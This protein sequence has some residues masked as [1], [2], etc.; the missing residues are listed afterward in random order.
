[1]K[2]LIYNL[3]KLFVAWAMSFIDREK[4]YGTTLFNAITRLA[5]S[6]GVNIGC[7]RREPGTNR[8]Q[9]ALVRRGA[10]EFE[11]NKLVL[12]GGFYRPL[13]M[14]GDIFDRLLKRELGGTIV[15][16]QA[17]VVGTFRQTREEILAER[18]HALTELVMVTEANI[19][20][21]TA[22]WYYID[23]S[24][25]PPDVLK[26]HWEVIIPGLVA[27]FVRLEMF[28]VNAV[29]KTEFVRRIGT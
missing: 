21:T 29:P 11:P 23:G 3:W 10:N 12:P 5:V 24:E 7:I 18:G 25:A 22:H 4:P 8:I 1:M 16:H 13:E 2:N 19:S 9:V 14:L 6:V 27:A 26:Y 17:I 20:A 15:Y 28:G